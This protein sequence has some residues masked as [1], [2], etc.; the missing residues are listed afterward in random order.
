MGLEILVIQQPRN[1]IRLAQCPGSH[2]LPCPALDPCLIRRRH[3]CAQVAFA[4]NFGPLLWSI[5]AFRNSLVYHSLDKVTR[6]AAGCVWG[7]GQAGRDSGSLL[8]SSVDGQGSP[9]ETWAALA[10]VGSRVQS[11]AACM[12]CAS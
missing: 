2:C 4:F 3:P 11:R 8:A 7:E 12:R 5:I 6:W 1:S 9:V 10:Q